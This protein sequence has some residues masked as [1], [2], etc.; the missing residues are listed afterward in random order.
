MFTPYCVWYPAWATPS[1]L[2]WAPLRA[3]TTQPPSPGLAQRACVTVCA[4]WMYDFPWPRK[5]S[6]VS[7]LNLSQ[8]DP[9]VKITFPEFCLLPLSSGFK[10]PAPLQMKCFPNHSWSFIFTVLSL[11]AKPFTLEIC[12]WKPK[13]N[14][15]IWLGVG[16]GGDGL[17]LLSPT[18][19]LLTIVST[20]CF[21]F[22]SAVC[23]TS[24]QSSLVA[25]Y[26]FLHLCFCHSAWYPMRQNQ[27]L[28]KD[29]E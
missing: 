21:V 1:A 6:P 10:S 16:Q 7:K 15:N 5:L 12:H 22:G 24:L 19:Q 13:S 11:P 9:F 17:S 20:C 27:Y 4:E 2:S 14:E 3:G 18:L 28:R 23:L 25:R 26:C 29:Y 8:N